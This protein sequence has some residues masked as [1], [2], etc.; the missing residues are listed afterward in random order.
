MISKFIMII[1]AKLRDK[2]KLKG[3]EWYEDRLRICSVCE[4]NSKNANKKNLKHQLLSLLSF[5]KPYCT[6][7]F[8][9]LQDKASEPLEICPELKWKQI[10]E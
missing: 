8:C 6:N 2:N 5:K 9:T 10:E 4:F 3:V 7:C 1:K